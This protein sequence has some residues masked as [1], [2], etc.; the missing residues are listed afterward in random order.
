MHRNNENVLID[1]RSFLSGSTLAAGLLLRTS[2]FA[3]AAKSDSSGP[4]VETSTGKLRGSMEDKV[5][6]FKGVPYGASTAGPRRFLPPAKLEPWTGVRD[7]ISF[8]PQAPQGAGVLPEF[9]AMMTEKNRT[10]SEDCLHLHV[11]TSAL[12]ANH[13]KPVMVWLHG[14]GYSSGSANWPL[15][16]GS[17]LAAKHDV[18]LVGVNHRL[19]VFGHL[20][21]AEL[22][23]E[24]Y[25]D[26][27]NVGMLDIAAALEWVR[28]NISAFGGDPSKVLIFGESGGGGKV[29]TLM[30]M[31]AAHGLFHRAAVQ[32]ASAIKGIPRD[33]ATKSTEEFMAKLGLSKNQVDELQNIPMEKLIA[34]MDGV[35]GVGAGPVVDGHSLPNDPFDPA[36]P[37]ISENVPLLIGTNATE[38][39]GLI[40]GISLDPIDD[41]TLRKNVKQSTRAS[42]EEVDKLIA[43]YKKAQPNLTNLEVSLTVAS[44]AAVRAS[45]LTEAERK[46]A[47]GKAPVY[48]YYLT[49]RTPVK[50][51]KFRS[52][53]VL[54]VPFVFDH[55]DV[56]K[57]MT[58]DGQ[59]RYALAE[60]MS[61]AWATFARNGNPNHKGLPHWPAFDTTKRATMEF[62][63]EC[64]VVDDPN[65][66]ERL[67]LNQVVKA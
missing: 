47:L 58:G 27:G 8:G 13:K 12:G 65:H 42:D 35:R 14:G 16:D 48:M 39:S 63:D 7:A 32:S 57:E 36:A 40:P 62:N 1:R 3:A 41:A 22:G 11:W 18:V 55:V 44:D 64:K 43:V 67:A 25:S 56:A 29:S 28:D 66:E 6:A 51:G 37:K 46:V 23:G 4:V 59:D 34:A 2:S 20:Y 50:G 24:K 45:V 61:G 21:L 53:H 9:F 54:D 10:L 15:Y 52:P 31:P 5:Y 60:N 38:I 33:R 49:W 19:N 26:S 17:A 30:A